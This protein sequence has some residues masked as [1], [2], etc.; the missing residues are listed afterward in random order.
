M[1]ACISGFKIMN[2]L[3]MAIGARQNPFCV[4]VSKLV[5]KLVVKVFSN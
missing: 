1:H 3:C 5:Q 2:L 4:A